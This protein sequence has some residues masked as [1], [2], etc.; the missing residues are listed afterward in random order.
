MFQHILLPATGE[1]APVPATLIARSVE[2]GDVVAPDTH[3]MTLS[4][5]AA[6]QLVVQ[7]DER[8]LGLLAIG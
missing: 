8:N 6:P 5:R 3:L 2:R 7:I 4:P 1:P